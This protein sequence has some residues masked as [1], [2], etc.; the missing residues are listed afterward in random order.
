MRCPL[1]VADGVVNLLLGVLLILLPGRLV[2]VLG[3]PE[4]RPA[5]YASILGA[6]L[7]GIGLALLLEAYDRGR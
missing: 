1:L 3:I 4:P 2:E 5:F 6:V 7:F